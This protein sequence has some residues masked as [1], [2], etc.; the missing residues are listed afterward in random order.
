ML[1]AVRARFHAL[2]FREAVDDAPLHGP[3]EFDSLHDAVTAL[4]HRDVSGK[5]QAGQ[6]SSGGGV[7]SSGRDGD[8]SAFAAEAAVAAAVTECL[9]VRLPLVELLD[10]ES[11]NTAPN[12][13]AALL[14]PAW[15]AAWVVE[16]TAAAATY[17]A[18]AAVAAAGTALN[19]ESGGGLGSVVRLEYAVPRNGGRMLRGAQSLA[20]LSDFQ[21]LGA[22]TAH[23]MPLSHIRILFFSEGSLIDTITFLCRPRACWPRPVA[24]TTQLRTE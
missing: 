1:S 21:V 10:D 2:L 11:D 22:R 23:Y 12:R 9:A 4:L 20:E 24:A 17:A 7:C 5:L 19:G 3:L 13:L 18:S 16:T 6:S 14:Q 8:S 15:R